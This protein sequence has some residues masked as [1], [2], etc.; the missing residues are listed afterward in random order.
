MP[1]L[2][3]FAD[4]QGFERSARRVVLQ[5]KL[6][7][8][9]N[10]L[11]VHFKFPK[12]AVPLPDCVRSAALAAAACTARVLP[13]QRP[14]RGKEGCSGG[15]SGGVAEVAAPP[16]SRSRRRTAQGGDNVPESLALR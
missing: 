10:E 13:P 9:L 16:M 3:S 5:N 11:K 12:P 1:T 14:P 7:L 6:R 2:R 4:P 15:G 8:N